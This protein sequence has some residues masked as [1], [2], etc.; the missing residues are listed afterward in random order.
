MKIRV[1]VIFVIMVTL[2][3]T[4]IASSDQPVPGRLSLLNIHPAT[5][6]NITNYL[7]GTIAHPNMM[8]RTNEP[9]NGIYLIS[10]QNS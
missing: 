2:A 8:S 6:S 7:A 4:T 1:V 10:R 9:E 3:Q 5:K